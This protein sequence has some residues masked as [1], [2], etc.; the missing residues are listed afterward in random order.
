VPQSLVREVVYQ[1]HDLI[2]ASHPGQKRTFETICLRYWWPGMR[3][4][5][6]EYVKQCDGCQTRKQG[7]EYRAPMGKVRMPSFPFEIVNMDLV[8]PITDHNLEIVFSYICGRIYQVCRSNS[9]PQYQCR[10]CAR[11]Y[12]KHIIAR[13]GTGSILVTDR[14]TSF[15][16]VFFRETCKILGIKQLYTSAMHPQSNG[17]VESLHKT[18][19]QGLSHYVNASGTNWDTLIPYI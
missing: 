4:G 14:G 9:G 6:N 7:Y 12:V 13:H 11:A 10:V 3:E 19:N 2:F 17:S 18:P 1:N 8:G 16:S 15:T 5:V